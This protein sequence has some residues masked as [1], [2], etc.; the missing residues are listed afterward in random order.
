MK[1]CEAIETQKKKLR[2]AAVEEEEGKRGRRRGV[3]RE[4][5]EEVS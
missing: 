4:G 5:R 1:E 2:R 3:T